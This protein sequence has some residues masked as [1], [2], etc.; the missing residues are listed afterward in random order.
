MRATLGARQCHFV[1]RF[2]RQRCTVVTAVWEARAQ[3]CV[4]TLEVTA[5]A[6]A[7]VPEPP[8]PTTLR[9]GLVK[10]LLPSGAG[11]GLGTDLLEAQTY[12]AAECKAV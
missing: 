1:I 4:V 3:E 2:P 9:V 6:W 5:K 10:V 8:L 12:P 7:S 11:A